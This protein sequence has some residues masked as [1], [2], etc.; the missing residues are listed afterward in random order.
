[1]WSYV[2]LSTCNCHTHHALQCV[3]KKGNQF[4]KAYFSNVNWFEYLL[5]AYKQ[6]AIHPLSIGTLLHHIYHSWP[7]TLQLKMTRSFS[8]FCKFCKFD[9]SFIAKLCNGVAAEIATCH[10]M[11]SF[12]FLEIWTTRCLQLLIVI[13]SIIQAYLTRINECLGN[14]LAMVR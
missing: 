3:S 14:H 9:K 10:A 2:I 4:S 1:M 5:V 13:L 6:R 11:W 8:T 12:S 7:N